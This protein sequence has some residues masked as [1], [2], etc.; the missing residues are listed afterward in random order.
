MTHESKMQLRNTFMYGSL[1]LV[2]SP[3]ITAAV[4]SNHVLHDVVIRK[5]A[6]FERQSS[7]LIKPRQQSSQGARFKAP[8]RKWS[9]AMDNPAT[10]FPSL[11]ECLMCVRCWVQE[12]R[13]KARVPFQVLSP[14]LHLYTDM[15]KLGWGTYLQDLTMLGTW[16]EEELD[17]HI[18]IL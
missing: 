3:L 16:M 8:F 12:G 2:P 10:P 18:D 6:L 1:E 4:K 7:Q 5:S 14:F 13:W 9:T 11:V 15:S 17:L